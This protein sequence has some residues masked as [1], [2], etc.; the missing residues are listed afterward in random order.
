M[1][2]TVLSGYCNLQEKTIK[3]WAVGSGSSLM[4]A[5]STSCA[6][7]GWPV[8]ER[9]CG[10]RPPPAWSGTSLG[11]LL[12]CMSSSASSS[13]WNAATKGS[14]AGEGGEEEH[15]WESLAPHPAVLLWVG[16]LRC[17]DTEA[18]LL[19]CLCPEL[20][21]PTP[22]HVAVCVWA[23]AGTGAQPW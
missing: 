10:L 19:L 12:L 3:H 22:G 16:R 11:D 2:N 15:V 14:S 9:Q 23:D 18:E 5:L 20:L 21:C 7:P 6:R 8:W 1:R 17:G 4:C 13:Q